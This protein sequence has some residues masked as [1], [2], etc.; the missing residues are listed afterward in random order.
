MKRAQWITL[1]IAVLVTGS[2][3][4]FARKVP[5]KKHIVAEQHSEDDGHDHGSGSV[6]IDSILNIARKQLSP[7]QVLRLNQLE[8]SI[9]RGAVKQQQLDIYHQLAHFWADTG[10][11]FEPYAWYTAEA[12]RLENSEKNLNFA[13]RLF[14]ENLQMDEVAARRKWKALQAKDLFERSLRINP[15][16]DSAKIGL[17]SAYIFG[18]ISATPMEGILKIREVAEKDST[19]VYA[20]L[21]LARGSVISG[22]YDKAI[23]R[24]QIA[25]RHDPANVEAI[26]LLADVYERTGDK[27]A[28]VKWYEKSLPLV[29]LP[30][31]KAAIGERIKDL[32]K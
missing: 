26:L 7:E 31:A 32:K 15:S 19:N 10:K 13:A 8:N 30:E 16:N 3:Y 28:A 6:S 5:P 2:I 25:T 9:S 1:G 12:A 4:L 18:D 17:G 24:L 21:M 11:I 23:E 22:Q 27:T 14:L 20:Q 29:K